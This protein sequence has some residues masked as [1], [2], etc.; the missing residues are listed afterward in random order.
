MVTGAA[1]A[2][3]AAGAA[4]PANSFSA[5]AINGVILATMSLTNAALVLLASFCLTAAA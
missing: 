2:G 4:P 3:A 1:A 5:C